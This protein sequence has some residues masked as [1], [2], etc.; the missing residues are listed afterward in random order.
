MILAAIGLLTVI[1]VFTIY[2]R[3]AVEERKIRWQ[4]YGL[5]D[6]LRFHAI[7]NERILDSAV[8]SRLDKMLTIYCASLHELSLWSAIPI[9]FSLADKKAQIEDE[10]RKWEHQLNKP[11]NAALKAIYEQSAALMIRHLQWRHMLLTGLSYVT[12]VGFWV[13]HRWGMWLSQRIL[14]GAIRPAILRSS[15]VRL[16]A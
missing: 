6:E 11:D 7:S 2:L 4:L 8:F 5:R 3:Q 16:A 13:C 10:H 1:A 14:S 12:L 9:M 15:R